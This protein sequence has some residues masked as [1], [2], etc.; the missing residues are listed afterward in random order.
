[1]LSKQFSMAS[2]VLLA[3]HGE[4]NEHHLLII[5]LSMEKTA[6][7]KA[8]RDRSNLIIGIWKYRLIYNLEDSERDSTA[9]VQDGVRIRNDKMIEM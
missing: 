4:Q 2:W 7:S 6:S 9:G 3:E 8:V 1:M 5:N